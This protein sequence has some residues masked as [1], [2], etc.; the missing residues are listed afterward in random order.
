MYYLLR[1]N[2]G[3]Y[4]K[5]FPSR[6]S[7][8]SSVLLFSLSLSPPGRSEQLEEGER[9]RLGRPLDVWPLASSLTLHLL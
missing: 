6:M 3:D 7:A 8:L 2:D 4:H 1:E 5:V 9:G